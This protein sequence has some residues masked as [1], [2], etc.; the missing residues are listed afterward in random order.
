MGV[1][2]VEGRIWEEAGPAVATVDPADIRGLVTTLLVPSSAFLNLGTRVE[3]TRL[4]TLP[5]VA[6][7]PG[8]RL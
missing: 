4:L 2:S 5:R 1:F 7:K 3:R 8:P 6:P